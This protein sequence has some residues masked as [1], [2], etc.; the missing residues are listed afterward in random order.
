LLSA[1]VL[2]VHAAPPAPTPAPASPAAA[3]AADPAAA[4]FFSALLVDDARR[5][6]RDLHLPPAAAARQAAIL[7]QFASQ[8]DPADPHTL[9]LLAEAARTSGKTPLQKDSLRKLIA[10]DPGDLVAQA[11]YLDLVAA[12][13]QVLDERAKVYQNALD[14]PKLDPQV[15][16]EMALRLARIAEERGDSG[17][18]K[19]F[20]TRALELNDVNVVALRGLARIAAQNPRAI[21]EQFQAL[22]ALL[23]ADPYQPDAWIQ[24]AS[25]AR[26]ANLH[27]KAVDYLSTGLEQLQLQGVAPDG[28]T[29]F[30][31]AIEKAIL[32]RRAESFLLFSDLV[33]L[34]DAPLYVL[35]PAELLAASDVA[36]SGPTPASPQPV[37]EI[38]AQRIR[39]LLVAKIK[40]APNDPAPLAD[41]AGV[42]LT[43]MP[44]VSAAA[45]EWIDDYARLVAPDDLTLQ[46]LRGWQLYRQGKLEDAAAI[47]QKSAPAD[48][49][50][51]IGLARI[52]IDQGKKADAA[53]ALQDVWSSHP[54]GLLALQVAET[55]RRASIEL[56]DTL[57]SKQLRDIT[58]RLPQTYVTAHQQPREIAIMSANIRRASVSLG[59][60][61]LLTLRITNATNRALPIGR[62]AMIATNLG[63]S[64]A[65]R[66]PG[67]IDLGVYALEDLQRS[68]RLEP[69]AMLE[70]TV[71]V[72]QGQLAD[73]F[74]QSPTTSALASIIAVTSPLILQDK[75]LAPGLG[76]QM[77]SAGDVQ[78][79]GMPFM[80]E[81]DFR[82]F[83]TYLAAGTVATSK[84]LVRV[85]V[86]GALLAALAAGSL[87]KVPYSSG[88]GMESA[89]ARRAFLD[90]LSPLLS[91]TD[92]LLRA[93]LLHAFANPP[94]DPPL[95]EKIASLAGDPDPL[96]R[97]LWANAAPPAVD[98]ATAAEHLVQLKQRLSTEKDDTV[99]EWLSLKIELATP[100]TPPTAATA[101]ASRPE[102]PKI[103]H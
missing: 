63:L 38:L 102:P 94:A 54:I 32:G 56:T 8:L 33:R 87:E 17:Q 21:P 59:E 16:S 52:Y 68:F 25:L 13:S 53:R 49:M 31:L 93:A 9:K 76:G 83:L 57:W 20:F 60:P 65:V 81:A 96:V 51:Q 73:L 66:A 47:L 101:P 92:P 15:R 91:S 37:K 80:N 41:A 79:N 26:A 61:I 70:S 46:R 55:A 77:L 50:S 43:I 45:A 88:G 58:A 14:Q 4:R 64:A 6:L 5:D 97:I 11:D 27:D 1:C 19:D 71:R 85:Q 95:R 40:A 74:A 34:P 78:R 86:A 99:R 90:A 62:D 35:I 39:P 42:E 24:L 12:S 3:P 72:D 36:G 10:L 48:P 7:L 103:P 44:T 22:I 84:Q 30:N 28:E 69:H 23:I 67:A 89:P 98:R 2:P 82:A 29:W 18:E 75:K 100:P